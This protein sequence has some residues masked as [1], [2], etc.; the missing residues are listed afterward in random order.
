MPSG[1]KMEDLTG[2]TFNYLMLKEKIVR[3]SGTKIKFYWKC[4]CVCGK[5]VIRRQD[6]ITSGRTTSCGCKHSLRFKYGKNH[7]NWKGYGEL[8]AGYFATLKHGAK[9]REISFDIT[10]E[11][12]WNLFLE[13][14]RKCK[15]TGLDLTL[16]QSNRQYRTEE[17]TASLDRI[18]SSKGYTPSNVQWIHKDVNRMKNAFTQERFIEICKLVAASN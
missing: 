5:E 2:K 12:A 11:F 18:D 7:P 1:I 8:S 4:V 14:K 17:Q 6:A 16:S 9:H 10:L 15:L 3:E 13:Q